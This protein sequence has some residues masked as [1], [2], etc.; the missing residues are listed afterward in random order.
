MLIK[1]LSTVL[2]DHAVCIE[3][4]HGIQM[5]SHRLQRAV[6]NNIFPCFLFI[7]SRPGWISRFLLEHGQPMA[8]TVYQGI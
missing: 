5:L 1:A 7:I 4:C 2:V 8:I 3:F 6:T